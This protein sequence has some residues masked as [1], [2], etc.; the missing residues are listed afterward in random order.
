M[1]DGEWRDWVERDDVDVNLS[2][3]W[4]GRS[5]FGRKAGR[6]GWAPLLTFRWRTAAV[7]EGDRCSRF[8]FASLPCWAQSGPKKSKKG[9]VHKRD[10]SRD[11]AKREM[12]KREKSAKLDGLMDGCSSQ[13]TANRLRSGLRSGLRISSAAA[14]ALLHSSRHVMKAEVLSAQKRGKREQSGSMTNVCC[15][16]RQAVWDCRRASAQPA[17]WLL[18]SSALSFKDSVAVS[19]QAVRSA[20]VSPTPRRWWP[21]PKSSFDQHP[22]PKTTLPRMNLA[23]CD[24]HAQSRFDPDERSKRVQQ[25]GRGFCNV[26]HF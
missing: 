7:A 22:V 16:F 11:T 14:F 25:V 19:D 3:L 20:R 26:D 17:P 5:G 23:K 9:P 12:Q 8:A 24:R 1:D 13:A 10:A 15:P 4:S 6:P 21:P 2:R 18:G